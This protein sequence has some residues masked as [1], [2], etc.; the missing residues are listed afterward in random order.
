MPQWPAA[1]FFLKPPANGANF[2]FSQRGATIFNLTLQSVTFITYKFHA[3]IHYCKFIILNQKISLINSKCQD[4]FND[5]FQ[6]QT[7]GHYHFI[8]NQAIILKP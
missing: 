4:I 6:A 2:V 8:L 3:A 1:L 5:N 7:K